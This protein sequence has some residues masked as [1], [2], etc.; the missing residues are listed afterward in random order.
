MRPRAI[1]WFELLYI[2]TLA[3]G[4]VQAAIGW[5]QLIALANLSSIFVIQI[6]TFVI[7][8][9]LVLLVSR[10]RSKLA[11]RILVLCFA[12]GVPTLWLTLTSGDMPGIAIL[13]AVQTTAQV[14]AM[15][16]LF[17]PGANAWMHNRVR[18]WREYD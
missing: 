1:V 6:S 4:G 8:L 7:I 10:A 12:L 3:I 14:V 9:L 18:T 15:L 13:T 2:S 11:K 5:R 17:T 16:L